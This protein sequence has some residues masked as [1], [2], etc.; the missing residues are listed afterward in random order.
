M[1]I[2][3]VIGHASSATNC[4]MNEQVFIKAQSVDHRGQLEQLVETC[5]TAFQQHTGSRIS[6][7]EIPWARL[8]A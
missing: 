5:T 2:S 6:P 3:T 4:A 1:H 7:K 8:S